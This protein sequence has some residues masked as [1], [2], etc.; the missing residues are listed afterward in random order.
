MPGR[1]TNDVIF[2][3]RQAVEK[4][5]RVEKP[6]VCL[7]FDL[8]KTFDTVPRNTVW[9]TLRRLNV[10]EWLVQAIQCTYYRSLS[11]VKINGQLSKQIKTTTGVHQ[12]SILSPLLIII[13]MKAL[14]D[15][16]GNDDCT[17]EARNINAAT[18]KLEEWQKVLEM[19]ELKVNLGKTKHAETNFSDRR[20]SI[21]K[22]GRFPCSICG[23]GVGRNFL[24]CN[25]CQD[26]THFRCIKLKKITMENF[27]TFV[28]VIC[29]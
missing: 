8:E 1:T 17:K 2:S 14:R 21:V 19:H 3:L 16:L 24:K 15:E 25:K 23:K 7:F 11:F 13:V 10:P 6:M 26:W 28:C 20:L 18:K 12:R 22:T 29:V 9:W 4:H 5:R 27:Q